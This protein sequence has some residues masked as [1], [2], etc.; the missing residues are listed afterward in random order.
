QTG[1][2]TLRAHRR[3]G[4]FGQV[5]E[6]RSDKFSIRYLKITAF[7]AFTCFHGLGWRNCRRV[8]RLCC[9]D[10]LSGH[11]VIGGDGLAG[12]V[13]LDAVRALDGR[14]LLAAGGERLHS[15]LI[16]VDLGRG[17]GCLTERRL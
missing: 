8:L 4:T 14:W 2:S 5:R 11:L 16:V 17:V 9:S 7:A 6:N 1:V 12:V 10:S 15:M 3:K 13:S